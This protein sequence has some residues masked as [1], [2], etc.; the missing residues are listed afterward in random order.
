MPG[1]PPLYFFKHLDMLP[2]KI[3]GVFVVR[4]VEANVLDTNGNIDFDYYYADS[5][6]W[7]IASIH[8][9]VVVPGG[10]ETH[11]N[12]WLRVAENPI[13]DVIGHCGSPLYPFHHD[14]VIKAF[15]KNNKIVEINV[16]SI[17]SRPGSKSIC[18]EIARV[19]KKYDV[20]VVV[21]SDAHFHT[22]IGNLNAGIDLLKEVDFP[23][24]LVINSSGERLYTAFKKKGIDFIDASDY[25]L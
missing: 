15:G 17:K 8:D 21:N 23:E 7:V 18:T 1:A 20:R 11:T 12:I 13:V 10:R 6:E 14:E 9:N 22:D 25:E 19:C 24:E 5:I 2:R 4:G 3:G 16:G